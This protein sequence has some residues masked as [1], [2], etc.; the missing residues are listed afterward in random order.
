M[1]GYR[2]YKEYDSPVDKRKDKPNGNVFATWGEPYIGQEHELFIEGYGAVFY[3]P[4]SPCSFTSAQLAW[5][6]DYCKRISEREAREI[7]PNLFRRIEEC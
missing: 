7:H 3:D 5:V 4:N 1:K 2:F 6:R